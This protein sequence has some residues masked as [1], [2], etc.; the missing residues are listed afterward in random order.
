[1]D[2]KKL[3]VKGIVQPGSKRLMGHDDLVVSIRDWTTYQFKAYGKNS[4]YFRA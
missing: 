3:N 2:T 4:R 1:M